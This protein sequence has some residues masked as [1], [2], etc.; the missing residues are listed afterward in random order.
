MRFVSVP[1][2]KGVCSVLRA[3]YTQIQPNWA[4]LQTAL[5]VTQAD[6]QPLKKVGFTMASWQFRST[7]S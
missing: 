3:P 1:A 5:P 2:R 6:R 7:P 4:E